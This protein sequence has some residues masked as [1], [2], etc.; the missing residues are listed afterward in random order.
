M[1]DSIGVGTD[2]DEVI[3]QCR[4]IVSIVLL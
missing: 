2:A 4:I 3:V 1:P